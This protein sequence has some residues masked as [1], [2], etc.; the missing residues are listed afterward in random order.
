[1]CKDEKI[2]SEIER[3]SHINTDEAKQ[4]IERLIE[5]LHASPDFAGRYGVMDR[6]KAMK[7]KEEK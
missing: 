5:E 6:I 1:M 7:N 3:L 2:I 4:E